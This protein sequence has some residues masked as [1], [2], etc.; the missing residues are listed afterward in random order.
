M[1]R[2]DQRGHGRRPAG[3]RQMIRTRRRMVSPAL[4]MD[5]GRVLRIRIWGL[6]ASRGK[7]T[8]S[9]PE[10][11]PNNY[12]Y[13]QPASQPYYANGMQQPPYPPQQ[14]WSQ[15][16]DPRGYDLGNYM[17]AAPQQPYPP[18]DPN[19]FRQPQDHAY[20]GQRQG[21]ADPGAEYDDEEFVDGDEPRRGRRWMFVAAAALIGAIGVGGALAYTY[22]SLF[23]PSSG[24][25]PIVRAD[26]GNKAKPTEKMLGRLSD[27]ASQQAGAPGSEPQDDRSGEELGGP[28]RVKTI[29]INPGAM[30]PA[31]PPPGSQVSPSMPGV[32]VDIGPRPQAAAAQDQPTA[33]RPAAATASDTR[34]TASEHALATAGAPGRGPAAEANSPRPPR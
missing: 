23:A 22:K 2:S 34:R 21:Y 14:Q 24:R 9:R 6:P 13:G 31:S 29:P 18:V 20:A 28:K 30:A 1:V 16:P 7:V 4:T 8:I 26:Q 12:D 33:D 11:E 15:Q 17:P 32:M 5:N 3:I 19:Q 25:V 10:P 27:D